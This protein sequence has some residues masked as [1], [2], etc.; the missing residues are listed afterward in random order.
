ML[1]FHVVLLV[2]T[3][4]HLYALKRV[5]LIFFERRQI[6]LARGGY[7]ADTARVDLWR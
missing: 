3:L 5:P 6:G 7:A 4:L 1:S 2:C